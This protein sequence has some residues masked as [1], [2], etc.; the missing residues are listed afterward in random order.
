MTHA[1]DGVEVALVQAARPAHLSAHGLPALRRGYAWLETIWSF[2]NVTAHAARLQRPSA[3]T[4]RFRVRA[5]T[6]DAAEGL[7]NLRPHQSRRV[8]W[9]FQVPRDATGIWIRYGSEGTVIWYHI[10]LHA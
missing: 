3:G 7:D 9:Y 1:V 4:D 2:R 8:E 10:K 5:F 6:P